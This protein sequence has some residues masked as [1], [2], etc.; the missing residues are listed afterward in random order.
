[1]ATSYTKFVVIGDT[2]TGKTSFITKY[3]YNMF[4]EAYIKTPRTDVYC[5]GCQLRITEFIP[6]RNGT[7]INWSY[8]GCD[9]VIIVYDV[10]NSE[11][12]NNIDNWR[13]EAKRFTNAPII[14]CG[15]HSDIAGGKFYRS[16]EVPTFIVSAKTGDNI[17]QIEKYLSGHIKVNKV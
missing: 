17:G 13:N 16:E 7:I 1:M 15:T 3:L 4:S 11:S 5:K 9:L 10:H 2:K 6:S 14:V 12:Y 8:G